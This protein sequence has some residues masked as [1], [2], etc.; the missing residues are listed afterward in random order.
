MKAIETKY[1]GVRFRSRTEARWAVFFDA[2]NWRREYE[3]EG[4][5]LKSGRYLPDFKIWPGDEPR[6]FEVKP[7]TD[8]CPDDPRWVDL[9]VGSGMFVLTAYGMHRTADGCDK[10]WAENRKLRPH[11]GR[12]ATPSG[13]SYVIGPFWTEPHMRH[14]WDAA[15]GARFEFGENGAEK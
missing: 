13:K 1:R 9:A 15:S 11:A 8:G 7:F 2:M 5:E 6:W 4:F 3:P 10:A 14:A 12:I